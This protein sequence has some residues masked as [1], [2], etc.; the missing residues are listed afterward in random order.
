VSAAARSTPAGPPRPATPGQRSRA[1]LAATHPGPAL[2][3][4]MGAAGL[5]AAAGQDARGVALCAAMVLAGQLSIG[6]SNDAIDWRRD[7]ASGR[8]DKP[9]ARGAVDPKTTWRAA[10]AAAL[11]CVP[12]SLSY[13]R[14]A[15][16]TH[17]VA[18]ASGWTYNLGLKRTA[19]SWLPYAVSFGLLPAFVVL[20]LPGSPLPPAWAI[21]AGSLLGVGAHLANVLPDIDDDLATGVR[22]LPHRLG[23]RRT[24]WLAT[25]ALLGAT[26]VLV[27]GPPGQIDGLGWAALAVV[28]ALVL[29][30]AAAAA[31]QPKTPFLVTIAVAGI[32]VLLLLARGPT[33]A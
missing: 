8:P 23:R 15:G 24:R 2:A 32:D 30:G 12:L 6:W 3:V 14:A 7:A 26:V 29:L 31:A 9:V 20:G 27:V 5:A 25:A 22:G 21:V 18:V 1:L 4:T 16:A 19:L 17:L 11:V 10:T 33:L 13:G 28:A